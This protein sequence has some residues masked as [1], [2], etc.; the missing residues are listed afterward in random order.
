M[1]KRQKHYTLCIVRLEFILAL[2]LQ[3]PGHRRPNL[4]NLPNLKSI[5]S[6]YF[7]GTLRIQPS[8]RPRQLHLFHFH[9]SFRLVVYIA[10][11]IVFTQYSSRMCV[12]MYLL[13]PFLKL[14]KHAWTHPLEISIECRLVCSVLSKGA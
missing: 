14:C 12:G 5:D 11:C 1:P 9:Y 10:T 4:K 13:P 7:T 3:F 2:W 6:P 8:R